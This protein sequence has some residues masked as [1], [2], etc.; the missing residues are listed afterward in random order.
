[1]N[2]KIIINGPRMFDE[3]FYRSAYSDV[4]HLCGNLYAHYLK[5]GIPQNR[6]PSLQIFNKIYP[7]FN[8]SI[9]KGLSRDIH[10]KSKQEYYSHF[11][12]IGFNGNRYFYFRNK[13]FINKSRLGYTLH[14]VDEPCPPFSNN[15]IQKNECLTQCH[16]KRQI[17][18]HKP[19]NHCRSHKHRS[20]RSHR[21]HRHHSRSRDRH[22]S[23]SRGRHHSRSRGRHHSR[24]R[25]HHH[26]RSRDHHHRHRHHSCHQHEPKTESLPPTT[27]RVNQIDLSNLADLF[28]KQTGRR[29]NEALEIIDQIKRQREATNIISDTVLQ[30]LSDMV[31]A[32]QQ[33]ISIPIS[34]PV[35]QEESSLQEVIEI[36]NTPPKEIVVIN[37]PALQQVT[38]SVIEPPKE[39][40]ISDEAPCAVESNKIVGGTSWINLNLVPFTKN[41]G[42]PLTYGEIMKYNGSM[43]VQQL[44]LQVND[45]IN[46]TAELPYNWKNNST[47]KPN[48]HWAP[49]SEMLNMKEKI[50]LTWMIRPIGSSFNDAN[51]QS[52]NTFTQTILIGPIGHRINTKTDMSPCISKGLEG[53]N[54]IIV[55]RLSRVTEGASYTDDIFIINLALTIEVEMQ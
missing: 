17:H 38:D 53:H 11:H 25:D 55:G 40:I 22:H 8:L 39:I 14:K 5:V 32:P 2:R 18:K 20:H 49:N 33:G 28:I 37:E 9:Y 44:L 51:Q 21:S 54:H 23:R 12:H 42:E 50:N 10:F 3:N 19:H 47:I 36:V 27:D 35:P 26:S 41:N 6:L 43:S 15:P 1:M 13:M 4:R 31:H 29:A 30:K 48:F 24:S 46:F 7:L 52:P 16:K 45:G 34:Q